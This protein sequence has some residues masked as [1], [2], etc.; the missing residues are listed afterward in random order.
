[1]ARV[2]CERWP[3]TTSVSAPDFTAAGAA[4]ILVVGTIRDPATPYE[5]SETLASTLESGVLLTRDGDGHTG[6]LQNNRCIDKIVVAYLV[7]GTVPAE[8]T[9]C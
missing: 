7:D 4:P 6:F 2:G 8:G 1:M 3:L 9:R 5:W